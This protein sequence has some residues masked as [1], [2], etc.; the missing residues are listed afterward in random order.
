MDAEMNKNRD[1]CLFTSSSSAASSGLACLRLVMPAALH[2]TKHKVGRSSSQCYRRLH[3]VQWQC[4]TQCNTEWWCVK[5]P[6]YI[7]I[8][9]KFIVL[10]WAQHLLNVRYFILFLHYSETLKKLNICLLLHGSQAKLE[11]GPSHH[12]GGESIHFKTCNG[13]DFKPPPPP[14]SICIQK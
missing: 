8:K 9:L 11:M 4:T 13:E 10:C 2:S 14:A 12:C 7:Y 6:T 5:L 1:I 3:R